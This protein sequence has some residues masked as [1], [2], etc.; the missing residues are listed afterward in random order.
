MA[1]FTVRV[2]LHGA[3]EDDYD[4][5]HERMERAGFS[6]Q[7]EGGD[8]KLYHLPP[9]EYDFQGQETIEQVR[10]KAHEVARTVRQRPAILVTQG[11]RAWS[12]LDEV[13]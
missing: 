8:G 9:A 7:I 11:S 1:R 12:G 10:T 6:R 13:K 4:L 2:E 3:D 5:L